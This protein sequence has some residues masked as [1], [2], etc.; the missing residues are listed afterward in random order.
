[1]KKIIFIEAYLNTQRKQMRT[2][3]INKETGEVVDDNNGI[4]F[5]NYRLAIAR[6]KRLMKETNNE[7]VLDVSC[8]PV[9]IPHEEPPLFDDFPGYVRR[10]TVIIRNKKGCDEGKPCYRIHDYSTNRILDD[11]G[12]RG[13]R[14]YEEAK[15][16]A[17]SHRDYWL[18]NRNEPQKFF[19]YPLF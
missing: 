1:M 4:G 5:R 16:V 6:S 3:I 11:N 14:S 12:G 15:Q 10:V 2:R 8:I 18:D 19:D 17:L 13:Y 9:P 7:M